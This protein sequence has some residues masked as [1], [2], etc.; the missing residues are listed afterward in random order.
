[1]IELLSHINIRVNQ[2]VF[3][4]DPSSTELGKSIIIESIKLIEECGFEEFTFKKLA[5]K[6]NTTESSVY[7]YFANKHRLLIYLLSWYWSWLEY[8]LVFNTANVSDASLKL[9][10][11]I[12]SLI[13]E[14]E[15]F[16]INGYICLNSLLKIAISES[17]KSFL[18]REIDNQ[19]EEGFF[20]SYINL[21]A[22]LSKIINEVNPDYSYSNSLVAVIFEGIHQ[23]KFFSLHIKSHSD[24]EVWEK[25]KMKDFF[26][27]LAIKTIKSNG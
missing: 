24:F 20:S 6:I 17:V 27:N 4:K 13:D 10:I 15:N 16:M 3:L 14:D 22:R 2:K 8:K 26:I 1:M 7:R 25:N 12:E 23:Q 18:T 9:K 11:A 5:T 19:N 21:C